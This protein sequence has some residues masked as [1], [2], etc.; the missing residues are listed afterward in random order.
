MSIDGDSGD[1]ILDGTSGDDIINGFAGN[2]TINGNDGNDFIDGGAGDDTIDAGAGDDIVI[3]DA[4]DTSITGGSGTDI[5]VFNDGEFQELDVTLWG[6]ERSGERYVDG[7]DNVI[8]VYDLSFF[9]IE[10]RRFHNDGT[11]TL[12]VFDAYQTETW[13][14]WIRTYDASGTLTFEEFIDDVTGGGGGNT[15]P[16]DYAAVTEDL[17]LTVTGNLFDDDVLNNPS[18]TG[19]VVDV[20]NGTLI[21]SSGSVFITGTYGTLEISAN[22]DYSYVLNNSSVQH[23]TAD[24]IMPDVFA[25]DFT[26][27]SG[28][29]FTDLLVEITGNNDAPIA[30]NNIANVD[31]DVNPSDS[32]NLLTD[33]DGFGVDSDIE[34]QPIGIVSVNGTSLNPT[35][36]TIIAG[37]YGLLT[38][39]GITGAY[40]YDLTGSNSAVQALG[41]GS[42][43]IDSFIYELTDASAFVTA[44]LEVTILGSASSPSAIADLITTTEDDVVAVSD[45][46]LTN[47]GGTSLFVSNVDATPVAPTGDTIIA[48]VHGTLTINAAGDYSYLVDAASSAVQALKNGESL[49]DTFTYTA[50]NGLGSE[51]ANLTVSITGLNDVAIISGDDTAAVTEDAGNPPSDLGVLSVTD[52]DAGEST[53]AGGTYLGTY[54]TVQLTA[55]G[56]YTYTLNN[57]DSV[58]QSLGLGTEIID[59]IAIQSIDG[60]THN[61]NVSI[62]GT[63]DAAVIAGVDTGAVTEDDDPATLTA[64]GALTITDVDTAEDVFVADTLAGAHG[65]LS[66]DVNGNWTYTADNTQLAIQELA[67]GST[68]TETITVSSIDGTPHDVTITI[69]GTNDAAV[70]AGVDTGAVTEDSGLGEAVGATLTIA[71]VDAGELT[72]ADGTYGG[73]YGSISLDF[74]GNWTYLLNNSNPTVQALADNATLTDVVSVTSVDGTPH[75]VTITI[76]GTNDAAVIA[77]VDTGAVTEDDD[78]ATLTASGALTITD[79][80]TAEDVFVADTLAGAHGSLTIDVNGNWTYTADNTQLAIQELAAGSTLTETIT[81]SSIDGTPHDVT[82]TIN[83]T[84]DAA[85]IAGVDTGAV[86]EDSGLGEAVGATLTIADV[87]AGELTFADG[88]YGGTYGSISLDFAGNWTYLLNNSNPTVQALADNATLTDVVSVTSVDGTPHDV[89]ITI[90]GTNDAAVIAGADTGAVTEDDDPA[91]LTASGAL[92]ITDVDTAEDVFVADT[93]AGAHGS[94]TIDV[95]G[96]WTYT[97]DNTQLAIQ[98]L[99]AGSTLTET[100]T[101]SSIDGTPHDVTI[102][103]NGTNDIPVLAN[104]DAGTT[105]SGGQLQ[106]LV[107]NILANDSDAD[108]DQLTLTQIDGQPISPDGTVSVRDGS[109]TMS[110]DGTTLTFTPDGSFS[111]PTSFQY[112]ASDGN[113][114]SI[115]TVNLD[116]SPLAGDDLL[117]TDEDT[118]GIIDVFANDGILTSTVSN[119]TFLAPAANGNV[120]VNGDKTITYTPDENYFGQDQ[121]TYEFT[122]LSAGLTFEF[123]RNRP[124]NNTVDNIPNGSQADAIGVATDF[125]VDALAL[126]LDGVSDNYALRYTGYIYIETAGT[127]TFETTSDDGSK[128]FING[129]EIVSNDGIRV[130]TQTQ[131]G[132]VSLTAGYHA[133]ELLYFQG[134]LGET[135]IATVSGPDTLDIALDLYS[136]G[137]VGHNL[138][139]D[140]AVVIVNV[141]SLNDAAVIA[142]VDTGAVTEDDDPATLTASGALTITDVDTAEDVFV[143]DT[144]AG[145]HGSLSIDVN[146]NWTY[147]ADNTQLAIQELAAGSTLTET[148]TV[149]SIDG[150]PHDVTITINGTNDAAVIAGVDTGAVTEDDDPATL[151]AS[152]ALTITDVD[153]AEDVFVA[154]TLAGAH[155]SLSIDVNGNWTYTAD[156]TQLA[157]QE[158]AAG[159]TLTET[160]TV[161]SIDGTPHDVTITING[162][163]DAAVIAGVDTGAVTEDDDPATLTASGALTITDVDTAEDVFVADTLAGAHGSLSI[164]VNGNW[165]YTADN[166]QLA[167]QELAAGS[168]LTETITVSSIDGTPHDVTITINGTNDAAVIAGVDT[169]A[170]TEDDDPATLTASGALTITDVD[171]A[172]DVFVAD[173]L[174]GAHGS[175]TIDVNGNWTYTADNTQ[176]AIQELAAGSTLTETITVSSIDG[177]P[178]DVTITINGTNDAAVIAGVDTGAVTEDDDPATLT[179]SGALTITDVD[180]AEDVFVADTL[181]GAHGSLS[182]DVNGN[183][184]YTADNTQLA[185]QE[186]AAGS[187]LTETITVSS[188][189]GTPHDVTITINGT[190]D[191]VTITGDDQGLVTEDET[192]PNIIDSGKLEIFGGDAGQNVFV[193][194]TLAGLYGSLTIDADGNWIYAA[195][196]TQLAIQSLGAGLTLTDTITVS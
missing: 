38:I 106:I 76:N 75:D 31:K 20:V 137:I 110:S 94:L 147:T 161:S 34:N 74:A 47:D 85:V 2:D 29:Y 139:T 128:L 37:Q 54:G 164:D 109:V 178:H 92:T 138:R 70:I 108:G 171:T 66:I 183:W 27:S 180:T 50:A 55:A 153:T 100:I 1:N 65:S 184:T 64:S 60:T 102:T 101:V 173:T 7:T 193:A 13:S 192:N 194:G 195:D 4:N 134:D 19:H 155:G 44:N 59:T 113:A 83:G 167:I 69:N 58:V 25:Y 79:V 77:G 123:F 135:L 169:G 10:E 144:L 186:L 156:N 162:T 176:L 191:P 121:F 68:L 136:S 98:E 145:A 84:N 71:D 80:D 158:L 63:N 35:G 105:N 103:I 17:V 140:S 174:A 148:I 48:G 127:Y 62:T 179:A 126:E 8:D 116:I 36:N 185:I 86:T 125:D 18:V 188:I 40:T 175:L 41:S 190:N 122:G 24:D 142:G 52:A 30:T 160:I 73:T 141:A 96:N 88:T 166:T 151:T 111:G 177:T 95:N 131:N 3:Y 16:E 104:D 165:T 28:S 11:Y 26:D 196:N 9:Y 97:A 143:A 118:V 82:I 189:D 23:F 5:L 21:P 72:F 112:S 91:T 132:S 150:T 129:S 182:I 43:L 51:N 115:A 124:T 107:S 12:T 81:V 57:S 89:T 42:T 90:N 181:A 157:I 56:S 117:V 6:F 170:V 119:I 93:L 39:D 187:T 120:T 15:A 87:D 152:G 99:A 49:S 78:P 32:G 154:D 46:V 133:L 45:N 146:G 67:A 172:E 168:T 14:S 130:A 149:S 159:S 53:F 22:G 163:N 114:S 33:D 61:I